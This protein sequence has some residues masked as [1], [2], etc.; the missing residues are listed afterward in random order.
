MWMRGTR[1]GLAVEL[2]KRNFLNKSKT[3]YPAKQITIFRVNTWS[4]CDLRNTAEILA[5]AS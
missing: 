2:G 4:K 3:F 1:P 5:F